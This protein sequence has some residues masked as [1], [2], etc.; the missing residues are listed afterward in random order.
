VYD[1]K[2]ELVDADYEKG[3]FM[4][5]KLFLNDKPFEKKISHDV[6]A[7]GPVSTLM[8]YKDAEEAAALAKRGKGSLVGSIV[9]Y[10]DSF[11]A[12]T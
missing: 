11:V 6:E 1:G 9:S 8:P 12:E 3:A 4:S 2:H 5:P 7:F 10:D